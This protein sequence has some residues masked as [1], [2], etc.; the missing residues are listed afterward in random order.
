MAYDL[1][2]HDVLR[3]SPQLEPLFD[4]MRAA[5][6]GAVADV[7]PG[8]PVTVRGALLALAPF[9]DGLGADPRVSALDAAALFEAAVGEAVEGRDDDYVQAAPA[10]SDRSLHAAATELGR[11]FG[12]DRATRLRFYAHRGIDMGQGGAPVLDID[13]LAR[14]FRV[15][16]A[17]RRGHEARRRA[18]S[19]PEARPARADA[20][21][22]PDAS[23]PTGAAPAFVAVANAEASR[24]SGPGPPEEEDEMLS[25]LNQPIDRRRFAAGSP[26]GP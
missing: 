2:L 8:R 19:A 4:R 3:R 23:G 9:V 7:R 20:P 21:Q 18:A 26:G 17:R 13:G 24:R 16:A 11:R 14:E 15:W 22:V 10:V 5:A 6:R 12:A 25:L 1:P